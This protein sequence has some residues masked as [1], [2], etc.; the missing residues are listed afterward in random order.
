MR[1]LILTLFCLLCLISTASAVDLQFSISNSGS[2]AFTPSQVQLLSTAIAQAEAMWETILVGYQPGIAIAS[3]P[4]TVSPTTSGLAEANYTAT[5]NQGGFRLTTS[6]IVHFNVNQIEAFANWQGPG[7]NGLNFLDEI[8]AHEVGHVLGI[9]TLWTS[10]GLYVNNTFQYTGQ[11][12]LAA[13]RAEFNQPL[14]TYVPVENAGGSG[15]A[16][17]HWDQRMR[18]SSLEGNPSDPWS[19]SPKIGIVDPYGRDLG[20]DLLTGAVDPDYGEPFLS[21]TTVE[22]MR[23]LGYRVAAFEDFNGDGVVDG[24]D[25]D[26]LNANLGATGLGIDSIRFGDANRDRKIDSADYLLW[27]S[28]A[29]PEPFAG[30]VMLTGMAIMAWSRLR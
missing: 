19:L 29:V 21:R 25:R 20:L 30:L 11:H 13:F 4:I 16:N 2:P 5:T 22:A 10:N 7:A 1:R 12:A 6:G 8:I 28:A 3:V 17:A 15:T 18:S 27:E 23:D 26:I 14:A 24:S 9:G